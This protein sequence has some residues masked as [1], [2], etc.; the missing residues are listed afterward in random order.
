MKTIQELEQIVSE[1]EAAQEQLN[2]I[3]ESIYDA[4]LGEI[5]LQGREFEKEFPDFETNEITKLHRCNRGFHRYYFSDYVLY[6]IGKDSYRGETDY[7]SD[8][9]PDVIFYY[10]PERRKEEIKKWVTDRF[11][12]LRKQ[13]QE[14]QKREEEQ[15]KILY[16]SLK[17]KY[18]NNQ[19]KE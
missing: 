18:D 11:G 6:L 2:N 13:R 1:G 5:E 19:V 3:A 10:E 17:E 4:Y 12:A 7:A 16:D 14:K 8:V 15:E 9:L